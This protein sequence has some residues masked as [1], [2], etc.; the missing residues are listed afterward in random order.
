MKKIILIILY[1]IFSIS[2]ENK[3]NDCHIEF[4][5][6]VSYKGNGIIKFNNNHTGSIRY[7]EFYPI[8]NVDNEQF[9]INK[10]LNKSL[11][12]GIIIRETNSSYLWQKLVNDKKIFF[13]K[14]GYGIALIYLSFTEK[15]VINKQKKEFKNYLQINEKG[16]KINMID[17][18]LYDI[19]TKQINIIKGL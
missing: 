16:F 12:N 19:D 13:D 10:V 17:I 14:D 9:D 8:C 15:A 5:D 11:T 1:F 18:D 3:K 7:I 2:C 4:S 6:Y